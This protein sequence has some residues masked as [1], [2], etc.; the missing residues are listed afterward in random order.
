LKSDDVKCDPIIKNFRAQ[1]CKEKEL[2]NQQAIY[3]TF[4]N[5]YEYEHEYDHLDAFGEEKIRGA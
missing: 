5:E 3:A 2:R 4:T 1:H